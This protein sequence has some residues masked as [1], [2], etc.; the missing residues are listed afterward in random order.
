MK[1]G[2]SE[3]TYDFR[4]KDRK[5]I[6]GEHVCLEDLVMYVISWKRNNTYGELWRLWD[7][8]LHKLNN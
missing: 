5:P 4:L 3:C 2:L 6:P 1:S 8:E 7:I